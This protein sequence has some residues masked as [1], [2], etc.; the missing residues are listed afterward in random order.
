[1][2]QNLSGALNYNCLDCVTKA[3][4]MQLVVTIPDHPSL[5]LVEQLAVLWQQIADFS[6]HLQGLSLQQIH[7]RLEA[8]EQQ[9]AA[10]VQQYAPAASASASAATSSAS[11]GGT[12]G[13]AVAGTGAATGTATGSAPATAASTTSDAATASSSASSSDVSSSP[14]APA[15]T[16]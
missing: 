11:T 15:A 14:A 12:S 7:D 16:P 1:V 3:L 2:P 5:A 9:I 10:L 4:A 6:K 8:Y 13:A